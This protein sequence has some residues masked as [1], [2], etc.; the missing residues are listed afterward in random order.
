MGINFLC[1]VFIF[2]F[3]RRRLVSRRYGA[4][5]PLDGELQGVILLKTGV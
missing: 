3:M 1:P 2:M 5:S 4:A